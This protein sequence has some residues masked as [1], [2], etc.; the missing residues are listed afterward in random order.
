MLESLA[1]PAGTQRVLFRTRNSELWRGPHTVFDEDFVAIP[2]DGASWL[3]EHGVRLVGVD[4]LSVAPFAESA[5][6]HQILLAAGVIAVEGLNLSE[7]EPGEYQLCCLP[8]K[9][10]GA[11]GAPARGADRIGGYSHRA[12]V[13][14]H[15]DAGSHRDAGTHLGACRIQTHRMRCL[16]PQD[17]EE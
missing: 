5:P 14:R 17:D 9:I 6:T 15:A 4:Y 7:I 3:V 16:R 11:D 12:F 10:A 2:A 8:L 13:P 1:I